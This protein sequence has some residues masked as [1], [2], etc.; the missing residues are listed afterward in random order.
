M[1]VNIT[2]APYCRRFR[3]FQHGTV[4]PAGCPTVAAARS[5]VRFSYNVRARPKLAA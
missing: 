4:P 1:K 3:Q 5:Y 2:C